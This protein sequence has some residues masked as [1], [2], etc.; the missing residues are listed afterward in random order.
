ME[1]ELLDVNIPTNPD[2]IIKVIGVGGGGGNAVTNMYK[3]GIHDVSF[4]LCN[5]DRQALNGSDVPVK[6][7]LG[8]TTTCGLGSGDQPERGR[9][10]AE[11][12]EEE[13]RQMLSDGTRMA[14]IT[15]GMGGGTGTGAAPVVA[16]ISK[17]MGILTVG[18]VTIPFEFEGQFKIVQALEGVE[19]ISKHVDA[20]LVINNERVREIYSDI[21]MSA[22]KAYAKADEVLTIAAKSIAEIITIRGVQNLDFA[23][24]KTT[25]TDGGVALMSNGYGEGEGRLQQAIDQ[26]LKSPLLNNNDVYNAQRILF[27][28]Y[29]SHDNEFRIDEMG[30]VHKFMARFRTKFRVKWGFGFDDTLGDKIKITIL[31]TG[32]GLDDIPE[33]AKQHHAAQE[34][35]TEEEQRQEAERHAREEKERELMIKY[36]YKPNQFRSQAEVIVLTAEELDDDTLIVQLEDTPTY[37]RDIRKF[38]QLRRGETPEVIEEAS[39]FT[40]TNNSYAKKP[41]NSNNSNPVI[42]FR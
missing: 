15:A 25:M 34:L 24:V 23:D 2:S 7:L 3:E 8:Q 19:E 29:S 1:D 17:E 10:A 13:I 9:K 27:N 5:T 4:M 41:D 42:S 22:S 20:L 26:A 35:R 18:I 16:R 36:G 11:E 40:P 14:F 32:F 21:G 30:E 31:A 12:S 33:I 37:S 6:L 38:N 28:I 39:G